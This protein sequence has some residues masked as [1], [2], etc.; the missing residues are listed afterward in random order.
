MGVFLIGFGG[1]RETR[2]AVIE[3]RDGGFVDAG[4]TRAGINGGILTT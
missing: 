4:A 1:M 2:G 3:L